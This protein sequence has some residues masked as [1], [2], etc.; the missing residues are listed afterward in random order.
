MVRSYR[1]DGSFHN[2]H[3]PRWSAETSLT[4]VRTAEM[5]RDDLLACDYSRN[6]SKPFLNL[7]QL[8]LMHPLMLQTDTRWWYLQLFRVSTWAVEKSVYSWKRNIA[9][10]GKMKGRYME[11]KVKEDKTGRGGW[12]WGGQIQGRKVSWRL[13]DITEQISKIAPWR[14]GFQQ[15][16]HGYITTG[17]INSLSAPN[18]VWLE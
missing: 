6:H 8:A 15:G 9:N 16:Y 18:L 5:T 7:L 10:K 17:T 11:R 3:R 4:T 13:S 2:R 14:P 1:V 12:I